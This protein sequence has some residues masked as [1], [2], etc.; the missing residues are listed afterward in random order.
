MPGWERA[1]VVTSPRPGCG[2]SG[3]P[4]VLSGLQCLSSWEAVG[5]A[6]ALLRTPVAWHQLASPARGIRRRAGSRC[7]V[8]P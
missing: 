8:W 5:P 2:T 7:G 6:P 3:G 1:S 4:C